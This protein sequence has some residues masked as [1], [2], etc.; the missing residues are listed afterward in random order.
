MILLPLPLP[1]LLLAFLHFY[2]AS[3]GSGS[4]VSGGDAPPTGDDYYSV[5]LLGVVAVHDAFAR[6]QVMV[7]RVLLLLILL[8][9]MTIIVVVTIIDVV[10]TA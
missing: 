4:G 1:Q 2:D 9:L 5:L 6:K 3:V 8:L 10:A 7:A